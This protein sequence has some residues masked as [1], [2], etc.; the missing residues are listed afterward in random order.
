[1]AKPR[2]IFTLLY[3]DGFFNVS[4]NFQL[5]QVGNL[6]WLN[7]NY[8]FESISRS[9]D[10]LIILN[11]SRHES[12]EN[13]AAFLN[14]VTKIAKYSFMPLAIGGGIK[15]ETLA[16]EY[17]NHGADK[18]VINT[19][20]FETPDVVQNIIKTFGAQAVVASVNTKKQADGRLMT[21]TRNGQHPTELNLIQ[22]IAHIEM[23]GAGELY[24]TSIDRDGTGAG[25]DL[26][27]LAI[28]HLH[29]RLPLI[30]SGGADT[31]DKLVQGIQSGFVSAVSTSH[32]FNFIGDGLMD[33]RASMSAEGINLSKW[34]FEA[35]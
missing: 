29:S 10:E 21:Y 27:G 4:R 30:A 14:V 32:L 11:V 2:L 9:I 24:L 34:K 22:A 26:E 23:I 19:A 20:Y 18:I 33:A 28:A 16:K 17:I 31:Y 35:T 5:Q 3:A 15:S 8:E 13:K 12:N 7:Y 1:M 6:D 25:Y